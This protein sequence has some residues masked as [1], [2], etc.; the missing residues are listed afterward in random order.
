MP[1]HLYESV[2]PD[3]VWYTGLNLTKLTED[4]AQLVLVASLEMLV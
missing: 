2:F 1:G 3:V 4:L